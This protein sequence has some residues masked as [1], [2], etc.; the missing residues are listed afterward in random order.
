MYISAGV[1]GKCRLNGDDPSWIE[2]R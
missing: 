2:Q 1:E